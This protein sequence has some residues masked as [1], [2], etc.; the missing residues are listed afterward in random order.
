[1]HAESILHEARR[2]WLAAALRGERPLWNADLGDVEGMLVAASTEGV[3]ALVNHE[4]S[5]QRE[6]WQLPQ[7]LVEGLAASTRLE[8]VSNLVREAQCREI[9]ARLAEEN[10]SALLLKGS[11][12]AYWAYDLPYLRPC[13]DIDLLFASR[14]G[15]AAAGH[16]LTKLGYALVSRALPGDLTT[17]ELCCVRAVSGTQIWADLHWGI[18]G[19][20]MFADRFSIQELFAASIA[21]PKL[22]PTARALGPVHAYLH[23]STHR[24]LQLHLGT[25]DRL[26]WHYDL[27]RLAQKFS[28]GD[29]NQLA[30]LC[31]ERGLAGA[32]HDAM[33]TSAALF[34]TPI[35]QSVVD[36]LAL[37]SRGERIDIQRLNKWKYMEYMNFLA[38]PARQRMRWLKQ[39]L[40]P[41]RVYLE[42][43]YGGRWTGYSRYLRKGL[44]KLFLGGTA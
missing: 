9:L 18:G 11:A 2:R 7:A 23:N 35:P 21:L 31:E 24:A 29:W 36:R 14:A 42:D 13:V 41:D 34:K 5:N 38:V 1:M 33:E 27:H 43:M 4:A 28:G 32:C 25:G 3:A 44:R 37:A 15:A 17:F 40:L 30:A 19:A 39:R 22:A 6:D 10:L 8:V 16:A 26:K 12:L 20:P